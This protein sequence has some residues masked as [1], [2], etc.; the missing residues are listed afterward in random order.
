MN[1]KVGKITLEDKPYA[2]FRDGNVILVLHRSSVK[3]PD[4][5]VEIREKY[6]GMDSSAIIQEAAKRSF[7]YYANCD[8]NS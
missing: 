6:K 7:V 8:S 2:E 3:E 4:V 5:I 1:T